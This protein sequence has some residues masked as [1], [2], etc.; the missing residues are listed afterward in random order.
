MMSLAKRE[1]KPTRG[2][3]RKAGRNMMG[4]GVRIVF[5]LQKKKKED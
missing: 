2:H 4:E 5:E 3:P 1:E